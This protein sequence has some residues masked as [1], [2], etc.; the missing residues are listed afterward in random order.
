MKKDKYFY[1]QLLFTLTVCAFLIVPVFM[2][3]VAGLTNNYFVGI[4]SGFTFRWVEQVWALYSDTIWLT[5]QIA[6]ATTLVNVV[7]GVPCAYVLAKSKSRWASIFDEILTL[8]IAIPGMAI[9]LGLILAYGGFTDFRSSWMFILVGHVIFTL[10]FMVKSVLSIL[11]SINFRVLEEGA[12]SLGA[13]FWQRFFDVIVP[14]CKAGIV[15][16]MLMTLTLSIG[17]FNLT[18]MLHT[19]LTKTL[20][21]GLADSYAAMRLEIS[22]AYTLIFLCLILPLLVLA[23]ALNKKPVTNN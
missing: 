21:V 12:A 20:P 4:K 15:A 10:P 7:V 2:S 23:Q 8:P 3:V 13:T 22:S 18:W 1:M 6:I 16:G 19:P 9:S 17:E 5:L 14:N 11:Q